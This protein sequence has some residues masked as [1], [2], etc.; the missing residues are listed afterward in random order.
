MALPPTLRLT[1][2]RRLSFLSEDTLQA[3]RFASILGSSFTAHRP[4]G[5]A[6]AAR[7]ATCPCVLAEAIAGRVLE[8][9]G[10]P[11]PVPPRPDPRRHLRGPAGQRAPRRCTA[12]PGSGSRAPVRPPL[13]VA[14]HLAR[15]A[16]RGDAEAIGW[17]T[18]A[19]REA[20]ARSP[21]VAADLL[22]R[23]VELIGRRTIRAAT[24]C[25]PNGPG[26]LM[27]AGTGRA[28]PKRRAARCSERDHDPMADGPVR[29]CL[30]LRA[31]AP[32]DGRATGSTSWSAQPRR[33]CSTTPNGHGALGWASIARMWLGDLDGCQPTASRP[34]G[35]GRSAGD[36][37]TSTIATPCS[38]VVSLLR[39][40]AGQAA[41]LS[42]RARSAGRQEPAAGRDT[43][44]PSRSPGAFTS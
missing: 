25:W 38:R 6:P 17:L 31:A 20:A 32:A 15:G 5:D 35:G 41:E 42:R 1:I 28:A 37:M 21:D 39:R 19:A 33:R 10:D 18:R 40:A 27:W 16:A 14:E 29:I 13:Q 7:L 26:S 34:V 12:R 9:D 30:G 43:A 44:I 23:A 2:L 4:V 3:L 8:D 11:A 22:G 36:H 24:G